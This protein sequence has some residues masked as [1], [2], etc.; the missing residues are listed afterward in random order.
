MGMAGEMTDEQKSH[1]NDLWGW[2]LWTSWPRNWYDQFMPAVAELS[3]RQ[4][5]QNVAL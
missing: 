2:F 5:A 1:L 3:R 4:Q